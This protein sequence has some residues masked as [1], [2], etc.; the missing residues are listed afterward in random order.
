MIISSYHDVVIVCET[1]SNILSETS[2]CKNPTFTC[3]LKKLADTLSVSLTEL[4]SRVTG[5]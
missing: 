5:K 2:M 1:V 4:H 3:A